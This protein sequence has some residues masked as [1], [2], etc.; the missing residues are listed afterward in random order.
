MTAA[1][2]T[3]LNV[4]VHNATAEDTRENRVKSLAEY[5]ITMLGQHSESVI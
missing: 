5:Q 4:T 2:Y 1:L 3:A